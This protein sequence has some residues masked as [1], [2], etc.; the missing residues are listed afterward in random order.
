[1]ELTSFHIID[2]ST[3]EALDK[4]HV[5]QGAV[6]DITGTLTTNVPFSA[7]SFTAVV[8][9]NLAGEYSFLG[10]TLTV[11]QLVD[12]PDSFAASSSDPTKW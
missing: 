1:M 6:L 7:E 12:C 2:E 4:L 3:G 11:N 8:R 9:L 10:M 5:Y